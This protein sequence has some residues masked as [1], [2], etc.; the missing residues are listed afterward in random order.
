VETADYIT[1][2]LISIFPSSSKNLTSPRGVP[3][4]NALKVLADGSLIFG[5]SS[6]L[7][8][9]IEM[10]TTK[11]KNFNTPPMSLINQLKIGR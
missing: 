9:N 2:Y 6:S 10:E 1:E 8:M 5:G 7:F 11:M 3:Y 4:G